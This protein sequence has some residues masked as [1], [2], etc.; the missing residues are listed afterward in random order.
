MMPSPKPRKKLGVEVILIYLLMNLISI[1]LFAYTITD[2]D[3]DLISENVRYRAQNRI[4]TLTQSVRSRS[5][6]QSVLQATQQVFTEAQLPYLIYSQD[7][8]WS[9]SP[10]FDQLP[11]HHRQHAAQADS[12]WKHHHQTVFID[13]QTEKHL[14]IFSGK[15]TLDFYIRLNDTNHQDLTIYSQ[16]QLH[17]I[18]KHLD[19]L[20]HSVIFAILILTLFHLLFGLILHRSII[21]PILQLNQAANKVSQGDLTVR[22]NIQRND[23]LGRMAQQFNRMTATIQHNMESLKKNM[24]EIK[25]AKHQIEQ[26]AMTDELT[27]LYNRHHLFEQLRKHLSLAERYEKNIGLILLDFD[28]FKRINDGYG[29]QAGDTVLKEIARIILQTS[30]QS[31]LVARYGG[32]EIIIVCPLINLQQTLSAGQRIRQAIQKATIQ[33]DESQS[34]RVTVSIGIAEFQALR[35]KSGHIPSPEELIEAADSAL[36]RAK[37]NGRNRVEVFSTPS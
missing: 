32:E 23:E 22:V 24:Q 2:N 34:V 21:K 19:T 8:I 13:F 3:I 20:L 9:H 14:N 15:Q 10:H 33:L 31:D 25:Q 18:E 4:H 6:K 37:K 7:S 28:F 36:Y 29:H 27:R 12:L 17:D 35:Q 11:F 30:R 26:M 1:S 16:L 5:D